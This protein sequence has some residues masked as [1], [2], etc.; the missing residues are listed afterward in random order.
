MPRFEV[1][2]A[3]PHHVG[4]V[5][6]RLRTCHALALTALGMNP[7]RN[8]RDAF[9]QSSFCRTWLVD[10]RPEAIGGVSGPISAS[11]G[12]VWVAFTD[13]AARWRREIVRE[14]RRQLA[15]IMSTRQHIDSAVL[16]DDPVSWR[17][18]QALGFFLKHPS[19]DEVFAQKRALESILAERPG[20]RVPLPGGG[21]GVIVGFGH[22]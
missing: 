4:A 7:H 6:H 13:Q 1:V 19:G 8:L 3:K 18:A 11:T 12:C 10:G 17:F 21:A 14:S 9:R 22:G 16:V 20:F 5:V 15:I 2:E